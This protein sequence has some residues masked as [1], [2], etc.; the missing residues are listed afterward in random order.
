[1]ISLPDVE[2]PAKLVQTLGESGGV[3]EDLVN[4]ELSPVVEAAAKHRRLWLWQA[5]VNGCRS[6]L[7]A[8]IHEEHATTGSEAGMDKLPEFCESLR[9]N[10]GKPKA[11]KH[12]VELL[13][14]LPL[15]QV[16]LNIANTRGAEPGGIDGKHLG[17]TIKRGQV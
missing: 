6:L 3:V 16:S 15:E 4:L 7:V 8:G 17:R 13:G 12:R 10:M 14:G 9:G 5:V 1:M 11:E 2:V